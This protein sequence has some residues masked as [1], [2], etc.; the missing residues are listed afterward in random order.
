MEELL[1]LL[2]VQTMEEQKGK[3][4]AGQSPITKVVPKARKVQLMALMQRLVLL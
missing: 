2:A 3:L 4:N 1:L